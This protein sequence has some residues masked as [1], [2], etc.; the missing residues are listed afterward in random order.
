MGARKQKGAQHTGSSCVGLQGN[1]SP[2]TSLMSSSEP[3]AIFGKRVCSHATDES[4]FGADPHPV[5]D[6]MRVQCLKDLV[7]VHEIQAA[8]TAGEFALR[9]RGAV[10]KPGLV[11][12]EKLCNR[13]NTF[14]DR[15]KR[16]PLQD[17][18]K[19]VSES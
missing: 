14:I 4:D 17:E 10:E 2:Y 16:Q 19:R 3:G 5:A 7:L 1:R 13:L 18:I 6:S 11:D 9:L 15:L 8:I 12:Y